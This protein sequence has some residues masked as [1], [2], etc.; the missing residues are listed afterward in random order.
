MKFE[1]GQH[2]TTMRNIRYR[3]MQSSLLNVVAEITLFISTIIIV[4][5]VKSS[6]SIR[7]QALSYAGM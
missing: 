6:F 2:C 7:L 5:T 4:L 1:K 3:L